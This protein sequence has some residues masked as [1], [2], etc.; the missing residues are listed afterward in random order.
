L[1]KSSRPCP[2][3]TR[4]GRRSSGRKG[5]PDATD[6]QIEQANEGNAAVA[7]SE[8]RVRDLLVRAT[9]IDV[10][11]LV[12]FLQR[13][14]SVSG[15][16]R[17]IAQTAPLLISSSE[18]P[19]VPVILDRPSGAFIALT[20]T[21][22][23]TLLIAQVRAAQPDRDSTAAVA[24]AALERA[25]GADPVRV[26]PETVLVFLGAVWINDALMLA[27]R[28]AHAKGAKLVFLL[29]DLTPVLETGHTAAVN[30]LFERYLT[31]VMQTASAVPAISEASRTDFADY[32]AR[33]GYPVPP[34]E[35]TGLPCG[36]KPGQF[37][38]AE[39][40][41]PRPLCSPCFCYFPVKR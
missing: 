31:L 14:E 6:A 5:E 38:T 35:A 37:D 17:V 41:W 28:D 7:Y 4:H 20:E 1:V 24:T 3:A 2:E 9:L 19:A 11:D 26:T 39:S 36:I 40:P 32:C 29:Y 23:E 22:V 15:V 27:A 30:R 33:S 18:H 21:E 16:Q 12:E 8:A 13:R 10:T 25:R 34:G